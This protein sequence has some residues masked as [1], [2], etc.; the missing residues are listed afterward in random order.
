MSNKINT[1]LLDTSVLLSDP[2]AIHKFEEHNVVIPITVI[3]ELEK[4]RTDLE[5]GYFA[6]KALREIESLRRKF[7]CLST[8]VPLKFEGNFWIETE[9]DQSIETLNS[10]DNDSKILGTARHLNKTLD[11]VVVSKDLPM[12]IIAS[13]LG[14]KAEEYKSE[15]LA[16]SEWTGVETLEVEY[17]VMDTVYD[18]KD[19]ISFSLD[20]GKDFPVNSGLILKSGNVS[21]LLVSLGDGY[22]ERI[23]GD[24]EVFGITGT[25]AE[26]RIAISHLLAEDVGIVSIGG[27]AGTGKSAIALLAGLEGVL[28][29]QKYK[30]V[31]V[32]R[33][34]YSVGGQ[35]LGFLP[36]DHDEKMNPWAQAVYDALEPLV[37]ENVLDEV[38]SRGLIEVLPLTHIRG[39]SL[40]DSFVIVDE[41]QSL[42]RNVIL[43]VLS[44][45][46]KNSK[47]VL[48]HDID[49][50]DNLRVGKYDGIA[51][52]IESLKGEQLFAHVT[53]KKSERSTIAELVTRLLAD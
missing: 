14:L 26:Q 11:V 13:T 1:Y 4:K 23:T 7:G 49:Q 48:T 10:S 15:I 44:R 8:P 21:A 22:Y 34:L 9:S 53:L 5:L 45:L 43:T 38:N 25:S 40:H 31:V 47:V 19:G 3:K 42:E 24:T 29:A 52:V 41:A 16:D 20:L 18:H 50:R 39:R 27:K 12:R 33:P 2:N 30:K 6:R 36:G 17:D 51:S 46:G 28:E 32:F 35:D 37:S